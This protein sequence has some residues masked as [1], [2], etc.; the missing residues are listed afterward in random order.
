MNIKRII[1]VSTLIAAIMMT[2]TVFAYSSKSNGNKKVKNSKK[3]IVKVNSNNKKSKATTTKTITKKDSVKK[4]ELKE[5]QASPFSTL[6]TNGTITKVQADAIQTAFRTYME[7][8]KTSDQTTKQAELKTLLDSLVAAGK[9]TQAVED[10]VLNAK[11]DIKSQGKNKMDKER[12]GQQIKYSQFSALVTAGTI[13]QADADV[14]EAALKTKMD[15]DRTAKQIA[16]Q[17]E[18]KAL[19]DGLVTTGKITQA[20]EDSVL[21]AKIDVKAQEENKMGRERK[22]QQSKRSQFSALV[23]AGTITQADSDAIETALKTKMDSDR[24]MKQTEMQTELKTV[25]DKLV[26]ANTITQVQE[27]AVLKVMEQSKTQ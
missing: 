11:A 20:V 17:A 5:N 7:S 27:E 21:N 24:S 13:T 14:I 23:T 6:I 18:L 4:G 3:V 1:G 9:I 10:S 8:A 25:L 16:K 26:T 19:L 2:S 15:S 22:G 12:K